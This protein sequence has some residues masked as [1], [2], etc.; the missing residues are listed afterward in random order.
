MNRLLSIL[1][2]SAITCQ[3]SVFAAKTQQDIG[4]TYENIQLFNTTSPSTGSLETNQN[5]L[6]LDYQ[7]ELER[8][9]ISG[10]MDISTELDVASRHFDASLSEGYISY[11]GVAG[12]KY[13][14]GRKV[15]DW[16]SS[17]QFWQLE[18]LNG[19]RS[20]DLMDDKQEGVLGLMI[21]NPSGSFRSQFFISYF[22]VPTLTPHL[23]IEDGKVVTKSGWYKLPP[24]RANTDFGTYDLYFDVERPNS[25]DVFLH[26]SMGVRLSYA[27]SN[28]ISLSG[29]SLYKPEPRL[30]INAAVNYVENRTA[31]VNAG[32]AVNHHFISGGEVKYTV[33]DDVTT[34]LGATFVDPTA[35]LAGDFDSLTAKLS[36]EQQEFSNRYIKIDPKYESEI[37]GYAA[38]NFNRPIYSLSLQGLKY[39]TEHIQGS[40]E[41]YS[42]T[43]K[44]DTAVGVS[45]SYA[46]TERIITSAQLRYDLVRK[47]NLLKGN[48]MYNPFST[49]L[50]GFSLETLK[51]PS[52]ESYWSPYRAQDTVTSYIKYRF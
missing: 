21:D 5:W 3:F 6:G 7:Y 11:T 48:I 44:W 33:N 20:F 32:A 28:G 9:Y 41:V 19:Q 17:E 30:R 40:D 16:N 29:Y 25:R 18:H 13:I 10:K 12:D 24:N 50:F 2:I 51:A 49:L 27:F 23:D 43:T 1:T 8:S 47:D 15:I 26:K 36:T 34:H 38:I 35:R 52:E 37:Y 45:G 31:Y 39:F 4:F 14:L 42:E 22:Y 46:L